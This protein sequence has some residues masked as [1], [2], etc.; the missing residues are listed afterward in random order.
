MT[1][2]ILAYAKIN[3][4]LEG[5]GRRNDDYHNVATVLHTI[6]LADRL[7]FQPSDTISLSCDAPDL[8]GE[9]NLVL[10]AARLLQ[11]QAG[12]S[13]G[14]AITLE[15]HIPEAAG[16]GGGSSDA[17]ATL[18]ALNKMWGLKLPAA[19]LRDLAATL[20]SDVPF[21]LDGGCALAEGR[22]EL[23]TP[24][25][26]ASGW[27]AVLVQPKVSITGKTARLYSMLAKADF[28][29]GSATRALADRIRHGTATIVDVAAARNAFERVAAVA[30]LGLEDY[31][32]AMLDAGAP[33]VRL[34]GTGPALY[35]LVDDEQTGNAMLA[36]LKAGGHEAYISRLVCRNEE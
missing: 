35:T 30:F 19:K 6:G 25:P 17:A 1:I 34:T 27:W 14:V 26:P 9:D 33:F 21:F 10:Q 15:K 24:L 32:Q 8:A 36:K 2:S 20:G 7:T 16:L 23:L 11:Q 13:M 22:G 3:L 29:D 12:R 5:L 18:K 31:R 4:A 28:S